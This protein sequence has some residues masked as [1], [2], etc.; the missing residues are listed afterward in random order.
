MRYQLQ[1]RVQQ[2][3]TM[4]PEV[5]GKHIRYAALTAG[6]ALATLSFPSIA[7]N[8]WT[9]EKVQG[10]THVRYERDDGEYL[11]LTVQCDQG[12]GI[13]SY[14]FVH[15]LPRNVDG[16]QALF[17]TPDLANAINNSELDQ[18]IT[19]DEVGRYNPTRIGATPVNTRSGP[20]LMS[21]SFFPFNPDTARQALEDQI[22][23][24]TESIGVWYRKPT[25]FTPIYSAS[26]PLSG[27]KPL[28]TMVLESKVMDCGDQ[29]WRKQRMNAVADRNA[30]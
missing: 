23:G 5:I 7:E 15:K 20:A 11:N 4:E 14:T 19:V 30:G 29:N 3:E 16:A 12:T 24:G 2:A 28:M 21:V 8:E 22:M 18:I 6:F 1:T 27:L 26:F 13:P 9:V 17:E 10:Q 25:T